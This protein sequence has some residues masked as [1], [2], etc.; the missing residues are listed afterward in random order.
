MIYVNIFRVSVIVDMYFSLSY[1]SN[2]TSY[3]DILLFRNNIH[4]FVLEDDEETIEGCFQADIG[5]DCFFI[6]LKK[7]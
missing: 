2:G 3:L 7:I 1:S 5:N 4:D 6:Q